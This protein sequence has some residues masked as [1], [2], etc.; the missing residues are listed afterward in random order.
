M[1]IVLNKA[2]RK[3]VIEWILRV[4]SSMVKWENILIEQLSSSFE[5]RIKPP[6]VEVDSVFRFLPITASFFLHFFVIVIDS[7]RSIANG[8]QHKWL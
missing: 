1:N 8:F 2:M 6:I 7:D 3:Y 5:S 4:A